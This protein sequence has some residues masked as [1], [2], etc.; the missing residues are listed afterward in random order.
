M[1]QTINSIESADREIDDAGFFRVL[2][3]GAAI[4]IPLTF[5]A[6]VLLSF[7]G[8]G[9]STAAAIAAWPALMGGPYVG[10]FIVLMKHLTAL[11]ATAAPVTYLPAQPHVVDR[12]HRQAA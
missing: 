11:D 7:V 4:G 8:V 2:A 3:F 12:A 10:G 5:V 6:V 1:E 9:L